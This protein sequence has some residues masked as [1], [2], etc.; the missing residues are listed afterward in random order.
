VARG[1]SSF[2]AFILLAALF[3]A[4]DLAGCSHSG[5]SAA[6]IARGKDIFDTSCAP[7]HVSN[8]VP[9]PTQPP[10]LDGLFKKAT[11]PSGAPAT[12]AQVR[13]TITEGRGVMPPFG[14]VI[15]DEDLDA[16]IAYLH[17]R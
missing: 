14:P 12:D 11:L 5:S 6:Q 17:T 3:A 8:S 15:H 10:N 4:I 13:K 1:S 16:L 2:G 9:L 7:C